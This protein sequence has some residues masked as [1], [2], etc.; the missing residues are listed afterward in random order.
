MMTTVTL[1][2]TPTTLSGVLPLLG[3]LTPDF[4]L[5]DTQLKTLSLADF[6][7]RR[8]LMNIVPSL[9]T[10]VCAESARAFNRRVADLD[11]CS[12]L[13]ISADLPFAQQRFCSI[14]G[15]NKAVTLS[16]M[17]ARTFA[18]DYGLLINEG[19]LAGLLA[20]AVLVLDERDRVIYQELVPE[21]TQ[22]P[23]YDLALEA[24][25][26]ISPPCRS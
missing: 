2:G 14:E 22:E 8:K 12:L 1:Q 11:D 6:S 15:L 9:D 5:V 17:C 24:L 18:E 25:R 19:P 21:I 26:S 3:S 20:R 10:P 16:T 7:G 4:A 23:N 13:V